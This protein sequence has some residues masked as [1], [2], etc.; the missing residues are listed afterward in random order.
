MIIVSRSVHYQ[1][2]FTDYF[3]VVSNF[4]GKLDNIK[5][6]AL[7]YNMKNIISLLLCNTI[8]YYVVLMP[9]AVYTQQSTSLMGVAILCNTCNCYLP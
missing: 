1:R 6:H 2:F 8:L 7:H 3:V 9:E 4:I 5:D